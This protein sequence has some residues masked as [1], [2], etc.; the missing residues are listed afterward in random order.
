MAHLTTWRF[1]VSPRTVLIMEQI[2]ES[3]TRRAGP[4]R[5]RATTQQQDRYLLL[6]ARRNRRSTAR[7]LQTDLKQAIGVHVSDQTEEN[8]EKM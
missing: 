7:A 2:A 1:G 6:C 8:E 5:R 4:G 3:Y